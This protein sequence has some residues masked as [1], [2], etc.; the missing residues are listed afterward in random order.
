M[1]TVSLRMFWFFIS[2]LGFIII[3]N[4]GSEATPDTN[5]LPS[6]IVIGTVFC[7][8]CFQQDFSRTNSHFISG[9]TVAVECG[10]DERS[11]KAS[12]YKQVKTNK[13]GK[14]K[15]HLPLSVGKHV[16]KIKEC[17]VKLIS[18]SEPFCAVASSAT[19]SSLHLKSRK[20]RTHIFSAGFFTFKPL[21]EP[22]LCN[23]KP[24]SATSREFD[25]VKHFSFTPSIPT[26]SPITQNPIFPPIAQNPTL[27]DILQPLLPPA[28]PMVMQPLQP[29]LPTPPITEKM[30]SKISGNLAQN[31]NR[32]QTNVKKFRKRRR[33]SSGSKPTITEEKTFFPT[34]HI[35]PILPS[36][37][38]TFGGIPLP[39][40]PLQPAPLLPNPLQPP[41][42]G[43][44]PLLPTPPSGGLLPT[45]IIPLLTPPPPP[46]PVFRFPFPLPP[47]PMLPL[48]LP[49]SPGFPGI[50]PAF[51]P[52]KTSP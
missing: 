41:S 16:K 45:P 39:P 51:H 27:P 5:N 4:H 30:I 43:L 33:M 52:K 18:S 15:V 13:H 8:A 35:P 21:K 31:S 34:P 26:F 44:P 7:D 48:P 37:Q 38:P 28:V 23:Q 2:I 36:P 11:S 46:P 17:T 1:G 42:G 24:S 14:F 50:P 25:S 20:Q 22:E 10:R 6:A 3:F 40:N 32:R 19:S 29:L 47:F 12:F 49:P 9:A